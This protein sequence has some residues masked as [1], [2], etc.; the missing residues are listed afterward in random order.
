MV[1]GIVQGGWSVPDE[2]RAIRR[3]IHTG[4]MRGYLTVTL[5]RGDGDGRWRL[6]DFH[7]PPESSR[8]LH[9]TA[10]SSHRDHLFK[11]LPPKSNGNGPA[12]R[13]PF[14]SLTTRS[15]ASGSVLVDVFR[16]PQETTASKSFPTVRPLDRSV[17]EHDAASGLYSMRRDELVRWFFPRK[18]PHIQF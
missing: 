18:G 8:V 17:C 12:N 5:R 16:P 14:I 13:V 11:E 1:V 7:G 10:D 3:E 2:Q 9:Q 15:F 4:E 6:G